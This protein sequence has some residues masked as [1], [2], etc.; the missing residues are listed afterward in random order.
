MSIKK[1]WI[2]SI[3][4]RKKVQGSAWLLVKAKYESSRG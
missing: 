1:D 4:K 3:Q 2:K